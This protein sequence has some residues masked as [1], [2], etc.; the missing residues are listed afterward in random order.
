LWQY[1][2]VPRLKSEPAR[3][4]GKQ[5]DYSAGKTRTQYT[6]MNIKQKIDNSLTLFLAAAVATANL[7]SFGA[8]SFQGG[9]ATAMRTAPT[10]AKMAMGLRPA[11][12]LRIAA[13]AKPTPSGAKSSFIPSSGPIGDKWAVVIGIADFMDPHIPKLKYSSKDARDFYDYLTSDT[14]GHFQKDHVRLLLDR[15]A[16]KV[17]IMDALGDS[18]LPHGVAPGDLVVIYVSTHGSPAGADQDGVNY[19]IPYDTQIHKLYATG[20]EM[21][22]LLRTMKERVHTNRIVLVMDTCYSGAEAMAEHKG[23]FRTNI[24]PQKVAEGIGSLVISSSASDQRSWESED[25]KNS[26]FTRYFIEALSANNS[27]VQID[28]AFKQ[29]KDKVQAAVLKDKGELQTP[30]IGGTFSGGSPILS[31]APSSVHAAPIL[32][33]DSSN[34]QVAQEPGARSLDAGA[35]DLTDYV[36]HMQKAHELINQHKLYEANHE[37]AQAVKSDPESIEAYLVQADILDQQA[38]YPEALQ[39]AN[40]A[41]ANDKESSRAAQQLGLEYYRLGQIDSAVRFTEAALTFDPGNADAHNQMGTINEHSFNKIDEAEQEYRK[42]L[43]LSPLNVN[44]LVA[45]G[46]LEQN[47]K[48]NSDDAEKLYRKAIEA[49]SDNPAACLALAHLLNVAANKIANTQPDVAQKKWK[50]AETQLRKALA[51]APGDWSLHSE[52]GMV[53]SHDPA[54]TDLA[55]AELRKGIDLA[56]TQ[57]APHAMLADFLVKPMNRIDE[58]DREYHK[59]IELD[60]SL[61]AARVSLG[62]LLVDYKKVYDESDTQ[63]R[64]ALKTNP[65][66][67]AAY[68]GLSH[69]TSRLNPKDPSAIA[70]AEQQLRKAI[71]IDDK[72]A[73]AYDQLGALLM[74]HTGRYAEA[75]QAFEKAVAL[76]PYSALAHYHLGLILFQQ[77]KDYDHAKAELT[78]AKDLDSSVSCYQTTLGTLMVTQLKQYKDAEQILR[79]ALNTDM[80]DAEAHYRLGMLYIEH[81]SKRNEGE[82]ELKK[83]RELDSDSKSIKMAY[84]RYVH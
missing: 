61:D 32:L 41:A 37:L 68:V 51:V 40:R 74:E 23:L 8:P 31:V 6:N 39:A 62:D 43:E 25:L 2:S 18:F 13:A 78:K 81:L 75:Q 63:F 80:R 15:D 14:G 45:L 49:D 82:D 69:V 79:G 46:L 22:A 55:E 16:T 29:M 5:R 42:A 71:T 72:Y 84:D 50:E 26:Y 83:A 28:V 77:T 38:K 35:V 3:V 7:A 64:A 21:S 10:G 24:N 54:R 27:K 76:D 30:M 58:A 4:K 47:Y 11:A 36:A 52:L 56:S 70:Q 59:A 9:H 33:P 73:Y 12:R 48:N 53:L 60:A 1:F 20:L 65:R 17:N 66:N 19:I 67:A 44:A 57:G 34:T